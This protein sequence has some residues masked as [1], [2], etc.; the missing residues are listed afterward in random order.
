[1]IKPNLCMSEP[2]KVIGSNTHLEITEAVCK[3]LLSRTKRIFI[4]EADHLRHKAQEAFTAS[5]Y[6][7][8]A[9]R[10]GVTLVNFS[11]LP[12][13]AVACPP[14]GKIA[15]PDLLLEADAFITLPVLKTHA[16]TYFTGALKNQWGCLPHYDRILFHRYLDDM[17]GSLHQILKPKMA[18]MDGI[19]GMEGRG[20]TNGKPRR[21]E[22]LLASRD[23]VAL[24]GTAMR[25][26]G[27]EPARA[28]HLVRAAD[29]GLGVLESQ[30][31][32]V[33]G[34]WESH[35]TEFEPAILD[36]A[37]WAMN[38][39]SR[40]RW[41]VKYV[42]EPNYVF[43]AGRAVVQFLRRVGAVEGGY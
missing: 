20:P 2:N 17:L 27:L 28:H 1:M 30:G 14:A 42:L 9:S 34:P 43:S 16:L 38:Y 3:V 29:R 35:Q 18:L 4:G 5:G 10:L 40:Y 37:I 31:I 23:S 25:L 22:V 41:F 8:L 36:R 39:M 6:D 11:E 7:D 13:S 19:V 12:C 32:L 21:M 24:D 15:L 33:E 26:I